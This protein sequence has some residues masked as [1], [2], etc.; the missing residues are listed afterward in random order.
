M[1]VEG[2]GPVE[3]SWQCVCFLALLCL[4]PTGLKPHTP[5]VK[6]YLCF[7]WRDTEVT[8]TISWTAERVCVH[9]CLCVCVCAVR[10]HQ[11]LVHLLA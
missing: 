1:G 8:G 4:A 9:P 7:T 6:L 5:P 3:G 10:V 11:E 2:E